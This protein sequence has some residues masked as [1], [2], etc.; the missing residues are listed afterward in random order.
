MSQSLCASPLWAFC[1]IF[2]ASTG[3]TTFPAQD[4]GLFCPPAMLQ[5]NCVPSK[6]Q[7]QVLTCSSPGWDPI[8]KQV[9]AD[10]PVTRRAC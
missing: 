1:S 8:G 3:L 2:K 10:E 4:G 5:V 6:R 7:V 9:L